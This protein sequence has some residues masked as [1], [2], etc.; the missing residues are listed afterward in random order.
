M[1]L[2][3][4][5]RVGIEPVQ[6][7]S[8]A[9]MDRIGMGPG[10]GDAVAVWWSAA[11]VP[12]LVAGLGAHGG[13]GAESAAQDF[14]CG[15]VTEEQHQHL[16]CGVVRVERSACLRNPDLHTACLRGRALAVP[17]FLRVTRTGVG[18]RVAEPG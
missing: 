11:E 5:V 12:A 7:A 18:T 3:G 14:A 15:L 2:A 9:G 6:A 10:I 16:V 17:E 8:P 4:G 13:G 1:D